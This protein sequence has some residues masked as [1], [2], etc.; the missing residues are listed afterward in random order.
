MQRKPTH[1]PPHRHPAGRHVHRLLRWAAGRR[2]AAISL[3]LRGACYGT[4]TAAVSFVAV[5]L[6][7]RL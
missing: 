7:N 3:M 1:R 2:R 6:Q 4:G 5:W